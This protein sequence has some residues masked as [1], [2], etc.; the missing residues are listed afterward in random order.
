MTA[1]ASIPTSLC[2]YMKR[3]RDLIEKE[4]EELDEI[5]A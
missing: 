4:D 3:R 2:V 1:A 5:A